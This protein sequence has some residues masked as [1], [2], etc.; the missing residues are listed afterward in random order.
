[1]FITQ[2]TGNE[3][4]VGTLSKAL[5]NGTLSHALLITGE[6]GTGVNFFASLLACD[7]V[8][9]D[10]PAAVS[11]GENP[12]VSIVRGSGA[13]G[14]I[15]VG[16]IRALNES[17]SY[18]SI[19]GAKRAFIIENCDNFNLSSANALLKNLEEPKDDITYILTANNI[20]SLPATVRSRCRVY[21][22]AE[23]AVEQ[24]R[25]YFEKMNADLEKVGEFSAV[26]RGNIG[27]IQNALNDAKRA[28]LLRTAQKITDAAAK[29]DGYAVSK[30][31][32]PYVKDKPS[33]NMIFDDLG[34]IAALQLTERSVRMS[35]AVLKYRRILKTNVGTNIAVENFSIECTK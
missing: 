5:Q 26:Y 25:R 1:M 21:T 29:H 13:S 24:T 12:L 23:P 18:S 17:R 3:K 27:K 2:F 30:M 32:Y 15:K 6:K 22:L 34:D 4:T 33:L 14:Q 28:E 20:S 9:A 10:S 16:D 8:N 35:E 7:I 11:R 31:L 19:A